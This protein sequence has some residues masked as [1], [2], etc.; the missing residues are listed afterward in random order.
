MMEHYRLPVRKDKVATSEL[1]K[2]VDDAELKDAIYNRSIE[3][4]KVLSFKNSNVKDDSLKL[5][6]GIAGPL[7][8]IS[9]DLSQN[10]SFITDA[11]VEIIC[12]LNIF[13]SLRVLNLADNQITDDSLVVMAKCP[14]LGKLEEL[15]LYG[16]S[17]VSS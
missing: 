3:R 11:A 12:E 15:I 10:F 4:A 7:N 9:L 2:I 1:L 8:I 16:N 6:R 5:L 13:P 14:W 17:D